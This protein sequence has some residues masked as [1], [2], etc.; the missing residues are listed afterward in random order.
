VDAGDTV[1]YTLTISNT[2]AY[3]AY[4]LTLTDTLPAALTAPSVYSVTD[5]A[6][7]LTTADF[8][9][10]GNSL[11][12]NSGVNIDLPASNGRTITILVRATVVD[13]IGFITPNNAIT[14]NAQ[15]TWTS[16]DGDIQNV[17]PFNPIQMNALVRTDLAR[18]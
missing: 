3:P 15:I 11:A 7:A 16:L 6:G 17:S 1:E 18:V 4:D 2:S 13:T 14:N 8:V 9:F 10:T 5:T 12:L